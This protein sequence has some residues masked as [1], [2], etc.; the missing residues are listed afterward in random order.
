MTL[1]DNFEEDSKMKEPKETGE[2]TDVERYPV[3]RLGALLAASLLKLPGDTEY[4]IMEEYF[5]R[6][7]Y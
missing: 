4:R 6:Q 5:P 7:P 1:D 2:N 3:S